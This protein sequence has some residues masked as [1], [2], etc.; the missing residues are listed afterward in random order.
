MRFHRYFKWSTPGSDGI[1]EGK[2]CC[3]CCGYPTL[4][5]WSG[6]DI[7]RL[8]WWED[9][10]T[11][12]E[13]GGG[14]NGSYTLGEARANFED[15]GDMYRYDRTRIQVVSEPSLARRALLAFVHGLDANQPLDIKA[16]LRLLK[17]C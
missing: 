9:D 3:P 12:D 2:F 7:C 17:C 5:E 15:H 6:Y 14:P 11:I 16:F 1:V 4:D 13:D 10:G 8:C